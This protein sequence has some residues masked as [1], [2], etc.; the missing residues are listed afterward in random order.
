MRELYYLGHRFFAAG[1][2]LLPSKVEAV[3]QLPTPTSK[4][5][6]QRFLGMTN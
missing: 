1:I 5:E 6:L 2:T 4:H 3:A